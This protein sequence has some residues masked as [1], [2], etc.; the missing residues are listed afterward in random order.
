MVES[1]DSCLNIQRPRTLYPSPD[2]TGKQEEAV[3]ISLSHTI[4]R[5]DS[6]LEARIN[7]RY[8]FELMLSRAGQPPIVMHFQETRKLVDRFL[9]ATDE[10]LRGTRGIYSVKFCQGAE[11]ECLDHLPGHRLLLYTLV[12]LAPDKD[13][14]AE[15]DLWLKMQARE[16]NPFEGIGRDRDWQMPLRKTELSHIA[17]A[18]RE[19]Y[20]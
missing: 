6:K 14:S 17:G 16:I 9:A 10:A 3:A 19:Y 20:L 15:G 1:S 8:G 13:L 7:A 2:V 18:M 5:Y 11:G 4:T 12:E